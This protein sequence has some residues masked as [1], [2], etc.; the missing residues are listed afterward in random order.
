MNIK[1]KISIKVLPT[2]IVNEVLA[3]I[4]KSKKNN[5]T[6]NSDLTKLTRKL[7]KVGMFGNLEQKTVSHYLTRKL[8]AS[9]GIV[10]ASIQDLYAGIG[11][12]KYHSDLT[13]PALNVRAVAYDSAL[14]IFE[15]IEKHNV[16]AV[17]FELSRGE[18]GFT[19][20]RPMQYTTSIL[21]AA[22]ASG[23]SGAIYFQGDHYQMSL[24]A[25]EQD[26][27][28]EVGKLTNLIKEAVA[29][30][31]YNIDIDTSTLVDLSQPTIKEQQELNYYWCA[32]FTNICRQVEPN[33]VTISVGGEIGEVGEHNTTE[34]EVD[35]FMEGLNEN[36][37][38]SVKTSIS[39]LSVQTGTKHGGNVLP[40]GS[41]GDMDINFQHLNFLGN[42]CREKHNLGG[43]V[44][45]G[46]STLPLHKFNGFPKAQC[47]EIHLAATL[48][49]TVYDEMPDEMEQE[50][51]SWLKENF[52]HEWSSSM[53]EPQFLYHARRFSVGP[54][55]EKWWSMNEENLANIRASLTEQIGEFFVR[56]NVSNTKD[57][58]ASLPT[59]PTVEVDLQSLY[60]I[61]VNEYEILTD[62]AD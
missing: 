36:L 56:L 4:E 6:G 61:N 49:N 2:E 34:A 18:I 62:L 35:A 51:Y 54:F 39:K 26:K 1:K 46:A 38:E 37:S 29:A 5:D 12:G 8:A 24:S 50:A 22:I 48:L 9:F 53:T 33:G 42:I 45:H 15:A 28:S 60:E 31:F 3:V 57:L 40:D 23:Y 19:Q 13:V 27:E 30:G 43:V 11:E 16:G 14:A 21:N 10:P 17:I 55:Q 59:P 52:Q 25:F 32:H 44:Q 41:L 7:A 47:L 20:Q 58:I